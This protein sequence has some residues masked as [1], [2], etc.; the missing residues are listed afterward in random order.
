MAQQ[1]L[2]I[3]S[4]VN[5]VSAQ[6]YVLPAIQREFVWDPEQMC[7]LFDSVMQGYPFGEFLFW[8]I[9]RE[10]SEDYRWYGFVRDYHERDNAHC[11][12]LGI[13]RDRALTAVLDGQQRLTAFNIGLR[14]SMA[15]KQPCKWR[16]S[17][18]AFPRRVL[19]LNLLGTNEPDE[20]GNRYEFEFVGEN[21]LNL[22]GTKLWFPVSL[23]LS[24]DLGPDMTEWLLDQ[25]LTREQIKDAHKTLA[26]LYQVIRVEP[27]VAY[28]EEQQQNI[29]RVLRIFIRRNSGGTVLSYSDLLLSTAVSQWV[30]L[31]ARKEVHQLVDDLNR[32][33]NGFELT[34]D[35]VLKAGLML[36]DIASV[37]FK[38]ENF[39][40][41]NMLVLED[42]WAKIRETLL[43]TVA[44]VASFG[45]DSSTIRAQ[46][47]LL[48]IAYYLHKR[49][50]PPNFITS[51]Q[52]ETERRAIS[53]WLIRS[54]LKK[55]GI[56]G[57][58]LDTLL[59]ALRDEIRKSSN[60]SFPADEI[61]HVMAQR[62]KSLDF[63]AEEMEDLSDIGYGD[64][65][66]FALLT[67]LFPFVDCRNK[68]HIDHIFP[69]S[70][71]APLQ[72]KKAGVQETELAEFQESAD[73]LA[74]LQLLDGNVN[75]E[76]QAKLPTEWLAEHFEETSRRQHFVHEHDL[77]EIPQG[78]DGFL[79]FYKA[80]REL[81]RHRI[82]QLVH[83]A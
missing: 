53:E 42:N 67:L 12:D 26:R 38:V 39:T 21:Q 43:A 75:V 60:G 41:S 19:A 80:R 9:A 83:M 14:G 20:D 30:R 51:G 22:Q 2:T 6:E 68:F 32:V 81:L 31:D 62:G 18:D 7:T 15:I 55:S 4:V 50:A 1:N 78:I 71:F 64:S 82:E 77:G 44:L 17:P 54:L 70:R 57:S 66:L 47:S 29:E 63:N 40:H 49:G 52:F 28:C 24:L 35:F 25:N 59:T 76:K 16:S 79:G 3:E 11:P 34:K 27:T 48:P 73:R 5:G 13:L 33:G 65:R 23:I 69:K 61:R 8:Q 45:F 58:G 37:G 56:W 36:T 74:N 46:S 10:S 72:L